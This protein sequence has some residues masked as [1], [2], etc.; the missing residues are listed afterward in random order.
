MHLCENIRE[1]RRD[2]EPQYSYLSGVRLPPPCL[3]HSAVVLDLGTGTAAVATAA[4][5]LFLPGGR[6]TAVDISPEML[7][8]AK[9]RWSTWVKRMWRSVKGAPKRYPA[10]DGAFDVVLA[11][12]R[13]MYVIDP[14][15]MAHGT[16]AT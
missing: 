15:G 7:M 11:S 3:V 16:S 5:P 10:E 12:L 2:W 9:R 8:L 4:A 6:V 14:A 1:A 13:L